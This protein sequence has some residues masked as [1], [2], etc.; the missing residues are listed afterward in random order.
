MGIKKEK[1]DDVLWFVVIEY[2]MEKISY[3][4]SEMMENVIYIFYYI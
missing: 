3:I 1:R 2:G 4:N